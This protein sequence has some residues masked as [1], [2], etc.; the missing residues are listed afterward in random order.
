MRIAPQPNTTGFATLPVLLMLLF[1]SSTMILVGTNMANTSMRQSQQILYAHQARLLAEG[2]VEKGVGYLATHA[3]DEPVE[4]RFAIQLCPHFLT[5]DPLTMAF[6]EG[7]ISPVVEGR[8]WFRIETAESAPAGLRKEGQVAY[9]IIGKAEMP[10]RGGES[11]QSVR[12]LYLLDGDG[13][14][15]LIAIDPS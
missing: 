10:Y 13:E 1:V 4:K 8:Y 9:R 5:D 2:A 6:E 11:R 15:R 7:E 12:Y 14:G 3:L